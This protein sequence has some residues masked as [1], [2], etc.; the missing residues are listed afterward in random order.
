MREQLRESLEAGALGL[1]TGLAYA[2]AFSASTDEVMQL[3]EELTAFGAVYTTHLRSEFEPVLEAMDEAFRIGRHAK[4]PVIISHLKCAGAGNWGAVRS[5]WSW[6][7][8][9]KPT[10]WAAIA[11][12]MRRALRPWISSKSP[13]PIASPSPGRRRTR[14][15]AAA[16]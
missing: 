4:V 1:S 7:V 3:T 13:M 2:S 11:I 9:R 10:R 6:S 15:W 14:R 5:C 12:P 16:T 8:R